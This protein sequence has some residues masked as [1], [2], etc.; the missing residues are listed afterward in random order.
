MF[1]AES[2]NENATQWKRLR[3]FSKK[4][5]P[6]SPPKERSSSLVLYNDVPLRSLATLWPLRKLIARPLDAVRFD[7]VTLVG[8]AVAIAALKVG[9]LRSDITAATAIFLWVSRFF[10]AKNARSSALFDRRE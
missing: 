7:L 10:F 6:P 4:F 2:P 3:K 5:R 9:T 8:L 1:Y